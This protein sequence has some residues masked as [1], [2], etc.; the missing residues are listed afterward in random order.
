MLETLGRPHHVVNLMFQYYPDLENWPT[1]GVNWHG[2]YR[3]N[4]LNEGDG[5]FP[6]VIESEGQWGQLYLKQIADVRA[7]GQEPQLT[8]TLHCNTPD[9]DLVAIAQSLRP[10]GRM[11]VRINHEC[12]GVWF[13]FNR[14]WSY[15]EVSDF[16]VRF[17]HILHEHAPEVLTV[18][19]WNGP[20]EAYSEPHKL[21]TQGKLVEEELAGMFRVCDIVSYDQYAS[22]HFDWPDP[23]FDFNRPTGSFSIPFEYWWKT[24]CDFH[25]SIC[26]LR[27]HETD[28][29]VHE[30]NE[31]VDLH[32]VYGQAEW[33]R[34]FYTEA[35][36]RKYD[37]LTN[38]T[39]YMFRDR[40]GLGLEWEDVDDPKRFEPR[41]ALDAYRE[42]IHDPFFAYHVICEGMPVDMRTRWVS[43]TNAEGLRCRFESDAS[44]AVLLELPRQQHV[45]V[46]CAGRW[47]V[48]QA[49]ED[50]VT[51]AFSQ[52]VNDVDM[53]LPP[54][55]GKNNDGGAYG[56]ELNAMPV[57]HMPA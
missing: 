17:H 55:D 48:K 2:F 7:H 32:G 18:G 51:V 25:D 44:G 38:I 28:I 23:A 21:D 45:L 29:E 27:G 12:N 56:D 9:A 10:Y 42:A 3:N 54:A 49:G 31:D 47:A 36:K 46:G 41:M 52:G 43:S 14:R 33:V 57:V 30:I 50:T 34:R 35:L 19:C 24:L 20:G 5:Y 40:G 11:R 26:E 13:Y 15:R 4:A 1:Q 16:F 6:L 37:W 22:L 53:F 8:L 39:F